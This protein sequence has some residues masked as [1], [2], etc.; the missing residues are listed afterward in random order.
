MANVCA[1]GTGRQTGTRQLGRH[2]G[3]C[4]GDWGGGAVGAHGS[5]A[6][7]DLLDFTHHSKASGVA[8]YSS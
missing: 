3:C 4:V 7:G 5:E 1:G 2:G 6:A 8:G